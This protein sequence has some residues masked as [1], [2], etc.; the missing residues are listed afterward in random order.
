MLEYGKIQACHWWVMYAVACGVT[1]PFPSRRYV[2][3]TH[4]M[5]F[6]SISIP[7]QPTVF[8]GTSSA[9]ILGFAMG[10]QYDAPAMAEDIQY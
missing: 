7:S 5:R 2:F 8:A 1:R 9:G 10:R 6:P 4:F 3:P